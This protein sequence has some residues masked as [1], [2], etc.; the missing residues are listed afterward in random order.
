MSLQIPC[1]FKWY[2]QSA[3]L[4]S[5]SPT[6]APPTL[7]FS[8][9]AYFL[10]TCESLTFA[11][12]P[13]SSCISECLITLLH[14]NHFGGLS[15]LFQ[16]CSFFSLSVSNVHIITSPSQSCEAALVQLHAQFIL[17]VSTGSVC[18]WATCSR[19]NILSTVSWG[20][21][22]V[23]IDPSQAPTLVVVIPLSELCF[24]HEYQK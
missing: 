7:I 12:E 21:I 11:T 16:L 17:I 5:C 20:G 23:E 3:L 18:F 13:I 8:N 15:L 1:R 24:K 14:S 4:V 2:D 22:T 19:E 10:N 6:V 9:N